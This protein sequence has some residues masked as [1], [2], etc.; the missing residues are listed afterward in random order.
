MMR[1]LLFLATNLAVLAVAIVV[2]MIVQDRLDVG[3]PG[4]AQPVPDVAD[5]RAV[6]GLQNVLAAQERIVDDMRGSGEVEG[7]RHWGIRIHGR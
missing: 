6:R 5:K 1:I 4:E 2:R 3:A 7:G